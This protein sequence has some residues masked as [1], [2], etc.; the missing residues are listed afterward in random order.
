MALQYANIF[1][2]DLE[3]IFRNCDLKPLLYLRYLDDIFYLDTWQRKIFKIFIRN[4]TST[5]RVSSLF[6]TF[7]QNKFTFWILQF[8]YNN[9]T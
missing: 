3:V 7:Q 4:L 5:T 2:A 1:M 8:L 9:K 6:W